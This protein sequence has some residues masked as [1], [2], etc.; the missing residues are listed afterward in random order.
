MLEH[1]HD[2]N[3]KLFNYYPKTHL[4]LPA[5]VIE[6]VNVLQQAGAKKKT[7]HQYILENSNYLPTSRDVHN[8]VRT[9]KTNKFGNTTRVERLKIWLK[10]FSEQPGNIAR[11]FTDMESGKVR[12]SCPTFFICLTVFL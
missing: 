4:A 9:L 2:L 8:L 10:D 1:N 5:K 11:N 12:G 6:T 3:V 7:I